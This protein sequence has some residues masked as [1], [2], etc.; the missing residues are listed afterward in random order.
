[1]IWPYICNLFFGIAQ[2]PGSAHVWGRVVAGSTSRPT[3]ESL[4][5]MAFHLYH[6]SLGRVVVLIQSGSSRLQYPGSYFQGFS[7][8][9]CSLG[10]GRPDSIRGSSDRT[11]ARYICAR[12]FHLYHCSLGRVWS[13]RFHQGSSR[14]QYP[15]SYFQGF[16]FI[17]LFNGACGRP[18]SIGIVDN[19]L[20]HISKTFFFYLSLFIN[21]GRPDPPGDRPDNR[22]LVHMPG[23][24]IYIIVHWGVVV[25][26][27]SGSSRLQYPGSYFQGF[28]IYII[29]QWACGRPD[30][31]GIVTTTETSGTY[32]P[33]F[34]HLYHCSMGRGR[35]DSIGS[36]RLQY[37]VISRFF[38]YIIVPWSS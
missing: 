22:S 10:R 15:G 31:T 9:H 2:E 7:F 14:L 33:G 29:V 16:S 37:P 26:I 18:D 1:M 28:F 23:F 30:S 25:L 36:S 13:S 19:T 8:Y 35:P 11:E 17:S 34:F 21:Y 27:Q 24:F 32:V 38:I 12:L 5:H 20:V 3:T 4:V 6:C